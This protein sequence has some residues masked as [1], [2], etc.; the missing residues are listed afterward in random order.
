MKYHLRRHGDYNC[1]A[2]TRMSYPEIYNC[3]L[4]ALYS[5]SLDDICGWY[6]CCG[7]V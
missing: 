2:L 6:K 7:Y 3:L 5:I 4:K 1:L